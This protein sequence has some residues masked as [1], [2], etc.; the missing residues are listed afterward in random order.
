MSKKEGTGSLLILY[1]YVILLYC[2]D[3]RRVYKTN[4]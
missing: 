1:N 2:I 4:E 3:I